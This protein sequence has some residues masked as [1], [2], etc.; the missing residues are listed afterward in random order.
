MVIRLLWEQDTGSSNLPIPTM[1][2]TQEQK[3]EYEREWYKNNPVRKAAV[4]HRS[5][6]QKSLCREYVLAFL[7]SHPCVDCSCD[8]VRV[9][10]F[11]HVRGEKSRNIS[12]LMSQGCFP[13]LLREIDKCDVR[14]A[15]CHRIRTYTETGS[16][17]IIGS[18]AE[19]D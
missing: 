12:T 3:R 7:G 19:M 6:N 14:C 10:E 16:Y 5:K 8:D 18:L 11:D 2:K 1:S 4:A 17:K 9:L 15:N 13:A